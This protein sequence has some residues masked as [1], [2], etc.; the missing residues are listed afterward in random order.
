M[1]FVLK[2]EMDIMGGGFERT[3]MSGR[4]YSS[5]Q[6]LFALKATLEVTMPTL[7]KRAEQ[8]DTAEDL[9]KLA[10]LTDKVTRNLLRTV[11]LNKLA[12]TMQNLSHVRIYIKVEAPGLQT[13]SDSNWLYVPAESLDYVLNEV[14]GAQCFGCETTEIQGRKCPLRKHLEACLPHTVKVERGSEKCQYAD[15]SLGLDDVVEV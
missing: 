2:D 5:L 4:E 10:E 8:A 9:E 6:A 1:Q 11:P 13:M 3:P 7:T 14:M 15:L 12:Q